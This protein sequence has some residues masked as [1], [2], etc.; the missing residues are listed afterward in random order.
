[1]VNDKMKEM[2][3]HINDEFYFFLNF[4]GHEKDF[5]ASEIAN[6]VRYYWKY[7]AEWK[8]Y[9]ENSEKEADK[10]WEELKDAS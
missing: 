7:E 5:S 2:K 6:V 1:M 4:L 3:C 9:L 10:L 8:E